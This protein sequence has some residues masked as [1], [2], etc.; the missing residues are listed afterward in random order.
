MR[1]KKVYPKG[2]YPKKVSPYKPHGRR[3]IGWPLKRW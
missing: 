3:D 1:P 2:R